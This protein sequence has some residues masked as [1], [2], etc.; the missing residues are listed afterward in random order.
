MEPS[1]APRSLLL[2]LLGGRGAGGVSEGTAGATENWKLVI[3][4]N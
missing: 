2:W 1:S 4:I 3:K